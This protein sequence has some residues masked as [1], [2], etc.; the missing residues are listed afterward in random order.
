MDNARRACNAFPDPWLELIECIVAKGK[1][2]GKSGRNGGRNGKKQKRVKIKKG[3]EKTPPTELSGYP[4]ALVRGIR[5]KG[6]T[7]PKFRHAPHAGFL[8]IR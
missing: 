6:T 1:E 8:L 5:A 2:E 4:M 7:P 3:R